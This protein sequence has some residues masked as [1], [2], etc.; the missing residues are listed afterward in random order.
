MG[1]AQFGANSAAGEP[2][3]WHIISEEPL[4]A[5]PQDT[6]E[7]LLE[8]EFI[9]TDDAPESASSHNG[10]VAAPARQSADMGTLLTELD[11]LLRMPQPPVAPANSIFTERYLRRARRRALWHRLRRM[12]VA[13]AVGALL[14]AA[15]WLWAPLGWPHPLT[16]PLPLPHL[17]LARPP[18]AASLAQDSH[19]AEV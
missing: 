9:E 17:G 1:N 2:P 14:G 6:S 12:A 19:T 15:V 18:A 13:A 3:Q 5:P 10:A 7:W 8:G 4:P 11:T 16:R